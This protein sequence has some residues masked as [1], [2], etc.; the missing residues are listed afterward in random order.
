MQEVPRP[1]P[2]PSPEVVESSTRLHVRA[3]RPPDIHFQ[4]E[5]R[6]SRV[7]VGASVGAHVLF[8]VLVVLILRY[9]PEPQAVEIAPERLPDGIVWLAEP[10]PGGGGGGGGNENPEPPRVAELP[11][12]DAI[13]VPVEKPPEIT[14]PTPEDEPKPV[15]AMNI[16]AK[17]L[18]AGEVELPGV[19]Q[20]A[21]L[22]ASAADSAGSGTGTGAGTGSG[23][24]VGAGQGSGLGEG[25]GGGTGGG[26]YRPGAGITLPRVVREVKPQYTADAMRAKVQG[27]VWLEC[28]VMPD[29]TVGDVKV[30]RSLDPV[31]G[32][33]QEA[34][35]AARQWRFV[36]GSRQ[37]EPVPVIITI[38]LTFTLR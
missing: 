37:G 33:D 11:G 27:T 12:K 7:G 34:I 26:A 1:R 32:L 20:S 22:A 19:L 29:G 16:P 9:A 4:F 15:E 35:K 2:A 8:V 3:D 25:F 36:P 18:S 21:N 38:E 6:Q 14:K 5:D 13:T 28:V 23:S 31:F 30:V 17:T 10:G 24:G